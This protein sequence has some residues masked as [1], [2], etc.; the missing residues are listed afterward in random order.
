MWQKLISFHWTFPRVN[1]IYF[2]QFSRFDVIQ[3]SKQS[4]NIKMRKSIITRI[5]AHI[6]YYIL[7]F[8]CGSLSKPFVHIVKNNNKKWRI[9]KVLL[10]HRFYFF[11][12]Y[13]HSLGSCDF[14]INVGLISLPVWCVLDKKE[15][16]QKTDKQTRLIYLYRFGSIGLIISLQYRKTR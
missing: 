7:A 13:K 8:C 14:Q 1:K 15:T 4:F 5:Y 11:F 16:N 9:S 6:S 2:D 10:R 12:A 3:T